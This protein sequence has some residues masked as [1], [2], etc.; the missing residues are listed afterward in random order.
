MFSN[1]MNGLV[2]LLPLVQKLSLFENRQF[3]PLEVLVDSDKG[4]LDLREGHD[5]RGNLCAAE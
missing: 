3:I 2:Y 4:S 5:S 1:W